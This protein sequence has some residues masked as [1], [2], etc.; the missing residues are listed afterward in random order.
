LSG[1]SAGSDPLPGGAGAGELV[2]GQ[3]H[4]RGSGA[5]GAEMLPALVFALLV[6]A[7]FAAL[8]VTQRLKHTPTLVQEFKRTS[9]FS[10][11]SQGSHRLEAISFK[12]AQA[13]EV[14]VT[15]ASS[16]GEAV[17]TLVR[18][19]AVARYKRLS[20]RW[21]GREGPAVGYRVLTS[22]NGYKSLLPLNRGRIAPAGE[23]GIRIELRGADRTIPSPRGFTLVG[24]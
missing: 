21:N 9:S 6:L 17:A 14:T 8:V 3:G 4:G 12:L 23:Y 20:L 18:D 13:D 5:G 2:R 7:C 24:R 15:I 19:R 11:Q 22:P 1:L 16:S 10:P